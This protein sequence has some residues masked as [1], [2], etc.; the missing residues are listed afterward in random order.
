MS[1]SINS[2]MSVNNCNALKNINTFFFLN[3]IL[4]SYVMDLSHY[5]S[6]NQIQNITSLD[7]H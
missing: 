3:K 1:H 6:V 2:Q 7:E 5:N 4:S